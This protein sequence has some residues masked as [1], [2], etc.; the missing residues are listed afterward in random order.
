MKAVRFQ[1]HG[2]PEVLRLEQ[3]ADPT[4]GPGEVLVRV[5]A[6]GVNRLDLFVREGSVPVKVPLPHISGSE[7]A[8]EVATL[9]AGVQGLAEG[10]RVAVFPYLHC[11]SCEFCLAGEPS[12]CLRSDILGLLSDGGY[13]ELVK[14]P[15]NAVQPLPEL[16]V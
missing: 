15:A 9:G 11:G 7:V 8:G 1:E 2:G 12:T 16:G 4:A 5:R 10:Q 14:V 3:V 13:A 6:C